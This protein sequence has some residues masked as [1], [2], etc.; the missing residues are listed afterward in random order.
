[1]EGRGGERVYG[2]IRVSSSSGGWGEKQGVF[3]V[4]DF[5]YLQN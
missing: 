2:Q 4:L 5:F 1:V 3:E